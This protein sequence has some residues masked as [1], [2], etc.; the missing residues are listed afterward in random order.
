MRILITGGSGFI[1]TN[2]VAHYLQSG[3]EVRNLDTAPPR[4]PAHQSVW[5]NVDI[6]DASALC[7]AVKDF[8]PEAVLHMAARTDLGGESIDAYPANTV[9]VS[10]VVAALRA[11]QSVRFAVFASTM[12]VCKIGYRPKSEYDYCP[13]TAYGESKV[14]GERRIRQETGDS[15]R[16]TI[17]RPTSIWGPWF[18]SPYRDFF[19][20]VEHGWYVHPSGKRIRRNYGF[21]L[22]SV[23]QISQ[24]VAAGGSELVGR[25][26][27]LADYEPIELKAWADAIQRHM[28]VRPVREL[29]LP[30]FRLAAIAGD[31]LLRIGVKRVP[32]N[33]FRLNNLLTETL[34][35]TEPLR[36]L[37]GPLP[38]DLEGAVQLTCDWLRSPEGQL[39]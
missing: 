36:R 16:W 4:N 28:R 32:L 29:P 13:S 2:L 10:N 14:D 12:L 17:L 35:D 9:G 25:T 39:S 30:L 6:T 11:S 1:G 3:D 23:Y 21:V 24:L 34:H 19:T 31:L 5:H 18:G 20:A 37:V 38:F 15:F 27:Y 7:R 26:V 8:A 22:N 33:S